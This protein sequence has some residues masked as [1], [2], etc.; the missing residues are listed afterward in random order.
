LL[1]VIGAIDLAKT[2]DEL[3]EIRSLLNMMDDAV[4]KL[5]EF[6]RNTHEYYNLKRGKLIFE[7]IDFNKLM[8]DAASIFNIAGRMDN[9]KFITKVAQEED[10][11]SDEN[12][13]KIILNN[14]FS[15]AFKFQKKNGANDKFVSADIKI[16]NRNAEIIVKDNGIGIDDSHIEKI[17]T[18]FYRATSDEPGSGFG[19]YNVKDA[20]TR[21]GGTIKVQSALNEGTTFIVSLPS[22]LN[23]P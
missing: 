6:I 7:K 16:I 5:D 10:F 18:M 14:L 21:L 9:V 13:I 23:E 3:T 8:A 19:L 17:F 20:I 12:S 2:M 1:S 22:K 4:K 11:C 15:N